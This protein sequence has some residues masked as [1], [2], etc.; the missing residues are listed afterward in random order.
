MTSLF[1]RPVVISQ[2]PICAQVNKVTLKMDV[3]HTEHSHVI[4]KGGGNI[5][6]VMEDTSCHIHFP[7]SNRNNNAGEKS[8]QVLTSLTVVAYCSCTHYILHH[9]FEFY[10]KVSI[11]LQVSI[12]GPVQGVESA[13][14]QIRVSDSLTLMSSTSIYTNHVNLC[15][16][17]HVNL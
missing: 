2:Q 7:D 15:E 17:K 14:R 5:K 12:A 16:F 11:Y 6:K 8:N 13:R 1:I 3:T 9:S 10:I 4:G